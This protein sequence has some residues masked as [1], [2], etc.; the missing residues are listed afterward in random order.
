[1]RSPKSFNDAH[2][3]RVLCVLDTQFA[4]YVGTLLA[5]V[6][7]PL[8][9]KTRCCVHLKKAPLDRPDVWRASD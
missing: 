8:A 2:A 3:L 1:M 7:L 5:N 4:L 6:M 9:A